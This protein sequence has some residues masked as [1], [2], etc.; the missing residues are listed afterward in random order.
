MDNLKE[1]TIRLFLS[2]VSRFIPLK[3]AKFA[4]LGGRGLEAK[5]WKD[6]GIPPENGWLIERGHETG[7]KLIVNHC[8]KTQNQLGTFSKILAGYDNSCRFIDAFH[9]DLCGTLSNQ[10][11]VDF[12]PVLPVILK[13]NGRCLAITV[14]D[15]RRN[16]ILEQW[17]SFQKR[18]KKLFGKQTEDI[19]S[20]LRIKQQSIPVN[21]NISSFIKPFD[22]EKATRRE[23]G[24]LVELTELLKVCG[25]SWIPV[26]IKR[27]VYVSRYKNRPFRMRTYFFHFQDKNYKNPQMVFAN[28]WANSELFFA[29]TAQ[30]QKIEAFIGTILTPEREENM[31]LTMI[32]LSGHVA[33][34]KDELD[35]LIAKSQQLDAIMQAL[36]K[37]A[38]LAS[39]DSP[40]MEEVIPNGSSRKVRKNWENLSD[41]E[42]IV[43]QVKALEKRVSGKGHWQNGDWE[44]MLKRDFGYYN[45]KLGRSCRAALA[46]TNGKFREMFKARVEK[47]F[48]SEA[49]PYLDRLA[50]I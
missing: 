50:K 11:M 10:A 18:A 4:T 35:R 43:W 9:L 19:Y 26:E 23:F 24:L 3:E 2:F 39:F 49:K 13:S 30:F 25:L 44:E 31:S 34:P 36:G 14:A 32:D 37:P 45:K 38:E 6:F 20:R 41:R 40:K 28:A 5:I 1:Q 16:L 47:V 15:A 12:A 29:N 8:Y 42:Q 22:V 7:Q 21:K 17:P 48:G 33:V 46:R 27:Y